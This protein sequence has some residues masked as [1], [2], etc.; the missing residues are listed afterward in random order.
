[1]FFRRPQGEEGEFFVQLFMEAD[2]TLKLPT[3]HDLLAKMF[4]EQDIKFSEVES[5]GHT[6]PGPCRL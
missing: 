5:P 3:I 1:M 4:R 6:H 2:P